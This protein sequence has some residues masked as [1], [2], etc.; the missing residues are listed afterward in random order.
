MTKKLPYPFKLTAP[1]PFIPD[2]YSEQVFIV[3]WAKQHEKR[4]PRLR[5]LYSSLG[6]IR[7]PIGLAVKAKAAGNKAGVPDLFLP[8]RTPVG[9]SGLYIELKRVK[10]G[11]VSA[12]Q[13]EWHE[14]LREQGYRVEVCRGAKAA[15]E[16]IKNYLGME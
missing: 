7:L 9:Y 14:A 5:L 12:E 1:K 3:A 15:I 8:V 10:L 2:E 16:V 6:G 4:E 11:V 13:K